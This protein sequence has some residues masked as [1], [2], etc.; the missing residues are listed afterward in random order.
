[1]IRF[2]GYLTLKEA[3]CNCYGTPWSA[4]RTADIKKNKE[5]VFLFQVAHPIL[6]P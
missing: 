3:V 1:M 5:T 6:V 2:T 4:C